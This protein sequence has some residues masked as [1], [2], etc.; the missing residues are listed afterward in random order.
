MSNID[1]MSNPWRNP[2]SARVAAS[3]YE[4]NNEQK[5]YR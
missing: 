3:I 4:K 1:K 5:Q 2:W